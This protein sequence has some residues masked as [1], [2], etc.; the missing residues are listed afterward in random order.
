M[1]MTGPVVILEDD[2]EDQEIMPD[3]FGELAVPNKLNFFYSG[4]NFLLYL[5]TTTDVPF[6]IFM[7]IYLPVISGLEVREQIFNDDYLHKKGIP[8]IFLTMSNSHGILEKAFNLQVQVL[9]QKA[10]TL[11]DMKQQVKQIV[12][13]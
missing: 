13:Y 2:K 9:F 11:E 12:D 1:A 10:S 4:K 8:Y 6:L 3:V 7:D 5:R